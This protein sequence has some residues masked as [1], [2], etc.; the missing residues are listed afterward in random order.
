VDFKISSA[1]ITQWT[2][3]RDSVV[4]VT[5][6]P[7]TV[8]NKSYGREKFCGFHGSSKVFPIL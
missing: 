1:L 8:N 3:K 4:T 5:N 7:Y 6:Q 2:D